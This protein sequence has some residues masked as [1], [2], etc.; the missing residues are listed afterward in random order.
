MDPSYEEKITRLEKDLSKYAKRSTDSLG[1]KHDLKDDGFRTPF[2]RDCHRVLHSLPFRRLKHKTQVFFAPENDHI[3]TRIEHSLHV[4]SISSTICKRLDLN[5]TL[6][7]AISLAHDLGHPPFGHLGELALN[8]IHRKYNRKNRL[9]KIPA[10]KHEAQSLRVIDH[11]KNRLHQK[12]NLTYEV[13]DGVVC[14]WGEPN[15]R[16]LKPLYRKHIKLVETSAARKQKPATLEGC[17]VRMADT[18]SYL[19]RDFEDACAAELVKQEELTPSVQFVLG[20]TNSEIIGTLVNDLVA[21][22]IGRNYL[23][24]SA[25]VFNAMVEMK[26]FNYNRIYLSDELAGQ[27]NRIFLIL[28]EL[29]NYFLE[30]QMNNKQLEKLRQGNH[31]NYPCEVFA[32]FL[33]DMEYP[34][35]TNKAQIASDFVSGMTDNFAMDCFKNLF[36]VRAVI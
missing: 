20:I 12:L 34:E 23:Q 24:F 17:V 9:A 31:K 35:E 30:I 13:R 14:H 33:D 11:F 4:A 18:I 16:E 19:G 36:H 10:F 21:N 29:F 8:D 32:I 26:T 27:R 5:A 2:E 6:A 7:E 25:R 15:E 22:S 28:D 1:R 3:C